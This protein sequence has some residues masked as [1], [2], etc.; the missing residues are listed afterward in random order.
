MKAKI[1]YF[2]Q[3]MIL[4]IVVLERVEAI[5]HQIANHS[6]EEKKNLEKDQ[7]NTQLLSFSPVD[8]ETVYRKMCMN[9]IMLIEYMKAIHALKKLDNHF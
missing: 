7:L 3:C 4:Y 9:R 2:K 1:G 6:R 8:R 5:V